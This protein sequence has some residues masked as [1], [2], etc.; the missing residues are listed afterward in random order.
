MGGKEMS[1]EK[2]VMV[3][4]SL[5]YFAELLQRTGCSSQAQQS[6]VCRGTTYQNQKARKQH[7]EKLVSP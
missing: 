1:E 2:T 6:M 4:G 3:A 5:D 7:G